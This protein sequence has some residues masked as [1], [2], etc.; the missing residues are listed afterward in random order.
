VCGTGTFNYRA[1]DA[2][3]SLSNIATGSIIVNCTNDAPV[4][5]N[6]SNTTN[7]NTNVT[8][9]VLANDTDIDHPVSGLSV[10]GVTSITG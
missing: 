10:T 4:A 8:T 2:S 5:V 3:G 9:F 1:L 6:D 7:R